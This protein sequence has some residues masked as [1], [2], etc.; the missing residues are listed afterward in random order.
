M[1]RV[2]SDITD[3]KRA[4]EV[5]ALEAAERLLPAGRLEGREWC[6]G[7]IAGEAGHSLKVCVKGAKVGVWRDFA[8]DQG[9]DL[10][11]LWQAVKS[12]TLTDALDDIRSWLGLQRPQFDKPAKTYRRP[13]KPQ[14][15]VPRSAV[16]DYLREERNLSAEA[17]AA[18]RIAE[19]GRTIVF[20]S[21]VSGELVAVKYR[22]IDDK[23]GMRV[24]AECEPV[25]Y[26][27]QAIPPN[28]RTVALVEGEIDAPSLW[29]YGIPALSVPFGGG[30]GAKQ[31]WIESEYDRL[32]RFEVIY[33]ALDDDPEGDAAV[34]EIVGR[35]GRHR[36]RR[37]R[38]PR[39]DAN[40]C[41]QDGVPRA[42]IHAAFAAAQTM[43]PPELVRAG[44]YADDVVKLFW[45]EDGHE[46][47]YRLPY[48][49]I[50]G[51]LLFRPAELTIWTGPSGHGKSQ[52]LSHASVDMGQQGARV[53]LASLE[54]TPP[55]S[56]RRM[57]KQAG[58]VDRPTEPFIRDIMAWI[59]EWLW[60]FALVGKVGVEPL[61]EAF[62]YARCRYGCDVFI[63]DS[64]MR[65]GI[66]SEDYEGQE[67]AVFQIVNWTVEK[68]VHTHLV[69]HS[70]KADQKNA[71]G[72][73]ETEDIKG[74]SEIGSNAFNIIGI[75][76]NRKLE[77][78]IKTLSE[79]I[80]HGDQSA[81][82][83]LA[84]IADKP[85]VV[86][87][88]AKQRS[89]DFEG[90]CGLWFNPETYQ[91]RSTRDDANGFRYVSGRGYQEDAA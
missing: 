37:V 43:D 53:C 86:L 60:C 85:P 54:M 49:K 15:T 26:G 11:D 87:N 58:N 27:W 31:R 10:I 48:G 21:L 29:D 8:A 40:E 75:W 17:I 88:V 24:E 16:L 22:P 44:R 7:S 59:D 73:P 77:D 20:P 33:L 30:K 80:E 6:A 38:L 18:Y 2:L 4:L 62:E 69:A 36:C 71:G 50:R 35:L 82:S 23:K 52:V 61:L 1:V 25:L 9:G 14:C 12:Q 74:A 46:P 78:Q 3:I 42:D 13:T 65:L 45:P 76:R 70:R 90:K 32:A 39:K 68:R 84:A 63:I 81:S 56:L 89:G 83:D 91:Y 19:Q 55:Q 57:V 66:G 5:R 79:K 72:A 64:L 67:K 51:K 28:A 47:G 34:E 41:L